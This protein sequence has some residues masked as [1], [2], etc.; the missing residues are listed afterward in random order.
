ME[1]RLKLASIYCAYVNYSIH[2]CS[3]RP[4]SDFNQ[5][6]GKLRFNNTIEL[7]IIN[8]QT[9]LGLIDGMGRFIIEEYY[10]SDIEQAHK[11]ITK[12]SRSGLHGIFWKL[13][14]K[15][16]MKDNNDISKF[17]TEHLI[18]LYKIIINNFIQPIR[19]GDENVVLQEYYNIYDCMIETTD[20]ETGNKIASV[21]LENNN[22]KIDT[23][24]DSTI[25]ITNLAKHF[26]KTYIN[27]P[28][29][30]VILKKMDSI[31]DVILKLGSNDPKALS[32]DEKKEIFLTNFTDNVTNFIEKELIDPTNAIELQNEMEL[33]KTLN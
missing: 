14:K 16:I 17:Y 15:Y 12:K 11:A 26:V 13:V 8:M 4:V 20:I 32:T 22:F 25:S 31:M 23:L 18:Q 28:Y 30:Y 5:L 24:R 6:W 3:Y 2:I 1:D 21:I 9:C 33:L 7:F 10:N 19:Y 27:A 29:M